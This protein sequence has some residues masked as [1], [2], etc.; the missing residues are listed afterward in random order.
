MAT[1]SAVKQKY[2]QK[3][4]YQLKVSVKKELAAEFRAELARRG[5]TMS[6][7]VHRAILTYLGE[8]D[9]AEQ[10]EER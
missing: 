7:V 1:S 3:T 4:Y 6:G 5:D 2:N 8:G 9:D 10:G